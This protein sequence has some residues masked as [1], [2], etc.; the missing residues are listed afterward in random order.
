MKTNNSEKGQI[1][2]LTVL[3]LAIFLLGFVGIATDYTNIWYQRQLAQSAADAACQA[4]GVDLLL[5]AEGQATPKMNFVPSVGATISCAASPTAAPC[6][7][8]A[9]NGTDG[10]LAT[11]TVSMSFPASFGA[12]AGP[13]GVKVPYV[14]LNVTRNATAYFSSLLTGKKTIAIHATAT[15]G[16]T[17]PNS[18]P[19]IV[20]L[21][22]TSA[23]AIGMNGAKD[24]IT[25]VGGPATSI[26]VNSNG[27]GTGSAVRLSTI[28]LSHAGPNNNGGN[29]AIFGGP[30]TAP[31]SVSFGTLPG[32]WLYPSLPIPD[33]YAQYSAPAKPAAGV[34]SPALKQN[35]AK[36][37]AAIPQ[38]GA[39]RLMAAQIQADAMRIPRVPMTM[40]FL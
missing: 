32:Q 27:N 30:A 37:K 40:E 36:C 38:G 5:V 2:V 19:P 24:A 18:A 4:A 9:Y 16:L 23:Q 25:V 12:L 13:P 22:P 26:Q 29:F 34:F 11:N 17:S 6:L 35:D 10:T 39:T 28:D 8:A 7:I 3:F 15:C 14:Q 31:G 21:H 1:L 33:P 20:V